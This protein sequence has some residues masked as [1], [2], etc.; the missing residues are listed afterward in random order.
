MTATPH[1]GKEEDFQIWL[2]L[3]DGDRFY[4]KFREG[5][6]KV[7]VSDI[8]RRMVK[9][10]LL[11]FD[12]TPLFPER[13]AYTANYQLSDMEALLYDE[14]TT[15][16]REE[17]NRA[18]RLGGQK[19]NNIG[20][21]L[22]MLQRR[23]A[24]SPEAI[25]QSLKR[26]RKRLESRLEETKHIVRGGSKG[27]NT[28]AETF[29]EYNVQKRIDIPD[30]LDELDEDLTA[31]E[32][33]MYTEQV[34][35]RASAAETIPEFEAEIASLK[36]LE[37]RALAIVQ[38]GNDKKWEELSYLLQDTPEMFTSK[39]TRRKLIIFTEHKDT[40]NYLVER[41][42]DMLGNDNAVRTISGS[43]SRDKRRQTQEEFRFDP[44]VIVLVATDA[45]GEGVNLQNANLMVNYDLPW[46][47]NRLEQRFGRIHRIGQTEI[48]HL[49]NI[50]ADETREGAVFQKLFEKIE[51]EKKA[52]GG[53]VFDVLGEAF[54]NI[55]LKELLIEAIR[56]GDDPEIKAKMHEVIEGALD[57]NH[58]KEII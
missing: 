30:N 28:V 27:T 44:E 52:L 50:V 23:L 41:I 22:T 1:N 13:R 43:T 46:N 2:S 42:K 7:D 49:W 54:D 12:G 34:V 11:K 55:S 9:E 31:E 40:L 37:H 51:I 15:Y 57:T 47:P 24:S 6:H 20:F 33:E 39:G 56:Y 21:A 17:M 10:E 48:C 19:K 36:S 45:A 53:K 38:S 16:V 26:R 29:I 8:M 35:D 58:L 4:G 25:Y 18:D 14:V 3:L 32:Y 5:A